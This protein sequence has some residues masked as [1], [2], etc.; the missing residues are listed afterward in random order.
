[1]CNRKIPI[2]SHPFNVHAMKNY[3]G[4]WGV[5]LMHRI[6]QSLEIAAQIQR[7]T[8][9]GIRPWTHHNDF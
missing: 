3:S 5:L 1:M 8:G 9:H 2:N 4:P 7:Y 6:C